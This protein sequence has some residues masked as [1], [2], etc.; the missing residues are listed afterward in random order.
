M[1][2]REKVIYSIERCTCHVPD[3]CRDCIYMEHP[4]PTCHDTL[5]NEAV[6]LLKAQKPKVMSLKELEETKD[7][8]F[9]ELR[10]KDEDDKAL[11]CFGLLSEWDDLLFHFIIDQWLLDGEPFARFYGCELKRKEYCTEWR[12]WNKRPT[13][14][15]M[16]EEK[17]DIQDINGL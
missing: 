5:L 1:A 13:K 3:A 7:P 2:D 15:R 16:M 10:T 6:E 12:P 8:V 14:E 9:I 11:T 17:W 4:Y